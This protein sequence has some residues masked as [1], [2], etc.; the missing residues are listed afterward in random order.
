M[1]QNIRQQVVGSVLGHGIQ[2]SLKTTGATST[3][4]SRAYLFVEV[5]LLV[6]QPMVQPLEEEKVL[7]LKLGLYYT[8]QW[9]EVYSP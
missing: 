4:K 2:P 8:G 7:L 9:W 3:G 5:S 1:F 6:R